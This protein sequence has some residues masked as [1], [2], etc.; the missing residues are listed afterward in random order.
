M[1]VFI[2]I[3]AQHIVAR[4]NSATPRV[5]LNPQDVYA[6]IYLCPF[7]AIAKEKL[8]PFCSLFSE[9]F[10]IYEYAGDLEKFYSHEDIC[11]QREQHQRIHHKQHHEVHR[12]LRIDQ[13]CLIL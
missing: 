1:K 8:S 12:K 11:H 9:D 4:L 7:E 3:T 6:L 2:D 13:L 10:E 5:N